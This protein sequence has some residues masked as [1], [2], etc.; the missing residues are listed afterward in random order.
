MHVVQP[1]DEIDGKFVFYGVGN[2]LSNQSAACCPAASQ[3]GLI[4]YLDVVGS[5]ETGWAV[6]AVS[7]VPTRVDRSDYTIVPLPQA[8]DAGGLGSSTR[9][10]YRRV[11]AET[12]EVVERLG[13][14]VPIRDDA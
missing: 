2:F 1:V 12:T 13:L 3:N 9:S 6:G 11:I 5:A 14:D 7:F 8:L 10:L 4:A